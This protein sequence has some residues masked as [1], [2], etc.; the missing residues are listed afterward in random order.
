LLISTW[1]GAGL[2]GLS[3]TK[4]SDKE[5]SNNEEYMEKYTI[6]TFRE[7]ADE[8]ERALAY[9]DKNTAMLYARELN[10]KLLDVIYHLPKNPDNLKT[11]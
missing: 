11:A 7:L 4:L 2:D 3:S 6:M 1:F 5:G 10:Q 9:N 8:I